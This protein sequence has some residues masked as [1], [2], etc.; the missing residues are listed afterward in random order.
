MPPA[1]EVVRRAIA[2]TVHNMREGGKSLGDMS[3]ATGLAG[4]RT[5][6][7]AYPQWPERFGADLDTAL[8]GLALLIVKAGTGGALFRGLQ[9]G[10]LHDAADLLGEPALRVAGDA[11]DALAAAWVKLAEV[12]RAHDHAAGAA[13]VERIADEEHA[14]VAALEACLEAL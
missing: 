10:F 3:G 12:A 6:A 5:L 8:N 1:D 13:L 2:T 9:A 11:Y 4:V 7:A 14:C